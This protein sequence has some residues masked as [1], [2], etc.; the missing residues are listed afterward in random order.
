[1]TKL[2]Q[3]IA[4]SG[5]HHK[6][7]VIVAV[8]SREFISGQCNVGRVRSSARAPQYANHDCVRSVKVTG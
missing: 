7:A 5:K 1:M 3:F 2:I 8:R 4:P 6:F